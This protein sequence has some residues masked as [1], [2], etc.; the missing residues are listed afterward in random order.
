MTTLSSVNA[1]PQVK[2][3]K[4]IG[5]VV[6]AG[7][8]T[9]YLVKNGKDIFINGVQDGLKNA[10]IPVKKFM[11]IAVAVSIATVGLT[12]GIGRLIGAGIGKI[13]EKVKQHKQEK[14]LKETLAEVLTENVKD[15]KPITVEEM[16]KIANMS[17]DAAIE[18]FSSII[19]PPAKE[20]VVQ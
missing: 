14:E 7:V 12:A 5:T 17:D 11:P 10:D 8:G 6:G 9:G 3:G 16:E 2:K 15:I 4:Q 20:K 18:Y 19:Q 1:N 13:V